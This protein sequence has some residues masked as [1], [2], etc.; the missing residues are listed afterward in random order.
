MKSLLSAAAAAFLFTVGG[1]AAASPLEISKAWSRPAVSGS[2][3]IGYLTVVNH[4]EKAV[5][6]VGVA[7]PAAARVEMHAMSMSG[8]VMSMARIDSVPVPAGGRAEFGPGGYHLMLVGLTQTT[9]VGDRVPA[10]VTF[11]SG[12]RVRT[13]LVVSLAAP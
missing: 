7:S 5:A 11:A 2:N 9:K 1:A 10:I 4:G 12:A 8:G 6:V 3:G 13:G